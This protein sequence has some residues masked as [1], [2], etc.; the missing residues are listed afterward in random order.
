MHSK[1]HSSGFTLIEL[2]ITVAI[3]GVLASIAIPAYTGYIETSQMGVAKQNGI[4]LAGFEETYFYENDTYLP[5]SYIPGGTDDLSAL[6]EWTLSG[7][8]DKYKY[9]VKAGTC[10]DIK[11]CFTLTITMPDNANISEVISRP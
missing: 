6:L 2:M 4:T 5:G 11:E 1:K 8:D 10:G 7:D 3:I 9:V